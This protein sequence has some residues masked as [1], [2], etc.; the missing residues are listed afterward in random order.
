MTEIRTQDKMP[1]TSS[2]LPEKRAE[3][4]ASLT[5]HSGPL[6]PPETVERYELVLPGAFDRILTMAEQDQRNEFE[7]SRSGWRF[8]HWGQFFGF[9]SVLIII[10]PYFA[11]LVFTIWLDNFA[12]FGAVLGAGVLAGLPA[13]VRSFQKKGDKP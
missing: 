6:P 3:M 8:A 4:T 5:L 7:L 9:V 10:I 1:E 11:V 12:M 13:L 2:Q